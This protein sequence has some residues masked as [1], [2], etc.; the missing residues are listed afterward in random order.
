PDVVFSVAGPDQPTT[1]HQPARNVFRF[2]PDYAQWM[3]GLGS[4]AYH[5]LGW[6]TAA[7]IAEGDP[8]GWS[9]VAGFVAEFCSLGG[10]VVKRMWSPF[11]APDS[12]QLVDRIPAAADGVLLAA[13]TQDVASFF[14]VFERRHAAVGRML[15]TDW[16]SLAIA[17]PSAHRLGVT[18]AG[19]FPW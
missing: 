7:T 13:G 8:L 6:R 12:S 4:Y 19:P 5:D 17:G 10:D 16:I 11:L 15:V 1:L 2:N 18:A 9:E 3:A 14:K